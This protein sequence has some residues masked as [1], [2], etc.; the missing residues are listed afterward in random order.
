MSE[1]EGRGGEAGV[2]AAERVG[3]VVVVDGVIGGNGGMMGG[4]WVADLSAR[5]TARVVLRGDGIEWSWAWYKNYD[6]KRLKGK[7][8]MSFG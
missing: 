4:T 7:V 3:V 5:V 1:R 2:D 8:R 6:L